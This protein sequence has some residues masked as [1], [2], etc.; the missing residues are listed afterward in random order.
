MY[1][2]GAFAE[3]RRAGVARCVFKILRP[4]SYCAVE[5]NI[6]IH[7]ATVRVGCTP[8]RRSVFFY[9]LS[10]QIRVNQV[11]R[12]PWY[13]RTGPSAPS[14]CREP[15]PR[16]LSFHPICGDQGP[17]NYCG[18]WANQQTSGLVLTARADQ[19]HRMPLICAV[20]ADQ[21]VLNMAK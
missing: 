4:R 5:R 17:C 6:F 7:R 9:T 16:A 21:H 18:P 1:T 8:R 2:A 10:I 12:S 19:L 3:V 15:A 20:A 13:T 14:D 11:P